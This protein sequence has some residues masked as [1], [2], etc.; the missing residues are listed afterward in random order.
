MMKRNIPTIGVNQRN[1][2]FGAFAKAYGCYMAVSEH[3]IELEAAVT[4]A[5]RADG[6]TI[7]HLREGAEFLA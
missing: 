7:I 5:I 4:N 2:D 6:A 3:Y 1:P